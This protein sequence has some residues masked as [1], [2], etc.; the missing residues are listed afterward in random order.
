MLARTVRNTR[1]S[2]SSLAAWSEKNDDRRARV[3][4]CVGAPR[5]LVVGR[6]L[7]ARISDGIQHLGQ[8]SD[9]VV[10]GHYGRPI[11]TRDWKGALV[12]FPDGAGLLKQVD[13]LATQR[14]DRL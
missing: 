14:Q 6:A 9:S 7:W 4:T 11:L 3:A 8:F 5:G 10:L 13:S 1:P 12:A 2:C